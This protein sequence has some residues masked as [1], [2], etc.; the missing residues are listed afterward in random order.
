[1][2]A[3]PWLALSLAVA[4]SIW[5]MAALRCLHPPGGALAIGMASLQSADWHP[6]GTVAI[7]V[8]GLM[9]GAM[10]INNLLRGRRYPQCSIAVGKNELEP[11]PRS[12]IGHQDLDYALSRIDS[13]LDISETDLVQVYN[14]AT[15]SAFRRHST[16]TCSDLMTHDVVTAEFATPL[17]EAWRLLRGRHIKALPV[18][19]RARRVIGLLTLDDFLAHVP[20]DDAPVG[21][22][23]RHF[24]QETPGV[25]SHKAEVAG[26]IMSERILVAQADDHLAEVAH[27]LSQRNHQHAIPVV[28][29]EG[30]LAGILSQTDILAALYHREAVGRTQTGA[31]HEPY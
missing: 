8:L 22:R 7:N 9:L 1:W 14:L 10:A 23:I 26:Q 12:G 3:V 13:F 24:L 4:L 21:Q 27:L 28:D 6:L 11:L 5:C 15:E 25:H 2:I 20:D 19:D 18:L 16:L 17:D 30:R 29:A 31:A